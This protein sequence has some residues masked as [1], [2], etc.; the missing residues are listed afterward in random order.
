MVRRMSLIATRIAFA[1]PLLATT[2]ACGP[3]LERTPQAPSRPDAQA[4]RADVPH[5]APKSEWFYRG[6][7]FTVRKGTD[8]QQVLRESDRNGKHVYEVAV[9]EAVL[10]VSTKSLAFLERKI[11]ATG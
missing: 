4:A 6:T 5:W 11:V 7:S 2:V 8:F 1:L 10:Y 3:A 9:P